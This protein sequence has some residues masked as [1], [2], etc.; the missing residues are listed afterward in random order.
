MDF[1]CGAMTASS[2]AMDS[3]Y[4]RYAE[5]LAERP[6][7]SNHGTNDEVEDSLPCVQYVA[8]LRE[9]CILTISFIH[10]NILSCFLTVFCQCFII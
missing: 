9:E 4:L 6:L 2:L 1:Q 3:M 7:A 5:H 10:N 8:A